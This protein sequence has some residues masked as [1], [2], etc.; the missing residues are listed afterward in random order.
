MRMTRHTALHLVLA[1]GVTISIATSATGAA[2]QGGDASL[3]G[4]VTDD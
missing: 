1:F 4:T 3:R 2:A